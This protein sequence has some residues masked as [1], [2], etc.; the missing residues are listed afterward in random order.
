M[1]SFLIICL[2]ILTFTP[3]IFGQTEEG[4]TYEFNTNPKPIDGILNPAKLNSKP[5]LKY[6][7]IRETDVLWEKR[8]WREIDTREK[9]NLTFRYPERPFFSILKEGIES[10]HIVA[11]SPEDDKFSTPLQND[12]LNTQFYRK[13][14]I[15]VMDPLNPDLQSMQVVESEIDAQDVVR[16][17]VKEVW[18]FDS[19]L[20]T[21]RKMILGIAPIF[22]E[23]DE[24]GNF[25]FERPL[26]WI[27]YPHCRQYLANFT[28]FNQWNDKAVMT[29]EDLF[30]MRFFASYI[31]KQS[32]IH[33]RRLQDYLSGRDLLLESEKIKMEIF[34]FEHDLWSY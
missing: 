18:F 13:D 23:F 11:Y 32:N 7:P 10:G 22:E 33:D 21:M 2:A 26:F 16:Y 12:E 31:T 28:V 15:A 4:E 30:E 17:R 20:S 8:I 1:K 6:A 14:T 25:L 3:G 34:N 24:D 29:W 19:Q 5:I 9:M 27:Y